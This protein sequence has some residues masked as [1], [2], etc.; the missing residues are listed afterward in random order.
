MGNMSGLFLFSFR[1][2]RVLK[3]EAVIFPKFEAGVPLRL[4][5]YLDAP[6][7][8]ID[9]MRMPNMTSHGSHHVQTMSP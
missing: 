3:C 7:L 5:K 2:I 8:I 6:I 1:L 4:F 9:A